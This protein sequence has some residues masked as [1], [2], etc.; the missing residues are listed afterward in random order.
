VPAAGVERAVID[1]LRG[2]LRAPEI[3][4]GT[5]QAARQSIEKISE[6]E[7]REALEHLDLLWEELFPG[8]QMRIVHLLVERVELHPDQLNVQLRTGGLTKL[9]SELHCR[10][11]SD[12]TRR[13]A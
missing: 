4:V 5:W 11:A 7:V 10:D 13:A 8:E 2:L 3:I 12:H 6:A 9:I 1:Q